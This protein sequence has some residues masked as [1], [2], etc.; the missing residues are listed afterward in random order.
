MRLITTGR[1][2][3]FTLNLIESISQLIKI[4]IDRHGIESELLLEKLEQY[5][6]IYLQDRKSVSGQLNYLKPVVLKLDEC[7]L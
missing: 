4:S 7:G 5:F 2:K 1:L 3:M 6:K